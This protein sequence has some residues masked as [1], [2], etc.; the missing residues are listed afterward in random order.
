M[1]IRKKDFNEAINKAKEETREKI[2]EMERNER[3]EKE[4][5]NRMYDLEKRIYALEHPEENKE[6]VVYPVD[7]NVK[8]CTG[9]ER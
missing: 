4:L 8:M 7:E 3:R 2:W 5:R 1:F 6:R 9:S